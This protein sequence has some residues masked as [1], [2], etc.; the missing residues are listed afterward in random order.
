MNEN[1]T[2]RLFL[3]G[4]V[5]TGRGIDQ[6]LPHPGDPTLHEDF[7]QNAREYVRLAETAGGRIPFPVGYGYIWGDVLAELENA[8]PDFRII[9]L[10]TAVTTKND[11]WPGKAVHYR[12]NPANIGCLTAA[13]ADCCC[14][15]NNHVLDWGYEGL[16]E[17]L[18]VLDQAGLR[19]AGAGRNAAEAADPAVLDAGAKGRV[20]VF[21]AGS[22]TSG[23]PADWAA[24]ANGPGVCLLEDLSESTARAFAERISRLKRPGDVAVA[25]IHWGGNWG[26]AIAPEQ[27]AFAHVLVENGVDVLHGHSSHHVKGF[28]AHRGR[29]ILHGCGDFI[30]DYEGIGGYEEYRSDLTLMYLVD[31]DPHSG[32]TL[33]ARLVPMRMKRLRLGRAS[34]AEARWLRD[35][36]NR[37]GKPFGTG[38]ELHDDN[39]MTVHSSG[40]PQA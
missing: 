20:L 13:R 19:R 4:D 2:L 34:K 8:R 33:Q 6:I 18:D 3:C 32:L 7:V 30:N 21:A 10:E 37:A 22:P 31:V 23:V 12:M 36:L 40:P 16:L 29:L 15:A 28:E 25:S 1:K 9:N 5:M 38:V 35:V 17:T 24:T 39:T 26:Y 11:Y 14:L 27:V